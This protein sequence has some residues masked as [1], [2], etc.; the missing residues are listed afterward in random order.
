VGAGEEMRGGPGAAVDSAGG[1][2]RLGHGTRGR[3][4]TVRTGEHRG[5]PT[6]GPQPT[7]GGRGEQWGAW[8]GPGK[9]K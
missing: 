2:Q 9:G 4:G 3:C 5:P 7:A 1:R 6:R 8:A